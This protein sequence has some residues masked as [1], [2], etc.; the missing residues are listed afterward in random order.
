[1]FKRKVY[2]VWPEK[3]IRFPIG[4][5]CKYD[6]LKLS[7]INHIK[8]RGIFCVRS[9]LHS[10]F[11]FLSEYEVYDGIFNLQQNIAIQLLLTVRPREVLLINIPGPIL[12]KDYYIFRHS[13]CI[14]LA[15]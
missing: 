14:S 4:D 7:K 2:D 3:G 11:F 5:N 9:T 1:M 13:Y 6:L 8:L 10:F 15:L 12:S